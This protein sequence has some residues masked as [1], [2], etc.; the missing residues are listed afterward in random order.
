MRTLIV[1]CLSFLAGFGL[2]RLVDGIAA[3]LSLQPASRTP[4]SMPFR[5][6]PF[7]GRNVTSARS[8]DVDLVWSATGEGLVVDGTVH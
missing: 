6:E 8:L 1:C 4:S 5:A 2:V 3:A 7:G